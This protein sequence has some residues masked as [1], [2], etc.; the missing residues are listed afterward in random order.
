[1]IFLRFWLATINEAFAIA[2]SQPT[3]PRMMLA[4]IFEWPRAEPTGLYADKLMILFHKSD[5]RRFL[6]H[7]VLF[8]I[9]L[10]YRF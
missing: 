4:L 6:A 8:D 1:M 3:S 5:E 10:R 2:V 9:P 7:R